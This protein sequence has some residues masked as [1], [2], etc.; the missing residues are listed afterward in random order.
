MTSTVWEPGDVA[1]EH[2]SKPHRFDKDTGKLVTKITASTGPMETAGGLY[3]TIEDLSR[4]AA[5]Q[6]DAWPPR[7]GEPDPILARAT[8][9]EAQ[10]V[11][12]ALGGG[13]GAPVGVGWA[14]HVYENCFGHV[15]R[16]NGGIDGFVAELDLMPQH[17]VAVIVLANRRAAGP[18]PIVDEIWRL[19][20]A[21]GGLEPRVA[22]PHPDVRPAAEAFVGLVNAWNA[23]TFATHA[24]PHM[25]RGDAASQLQHELAWEH[26]Q[27]GDCKLGHLRASKDIDSGEYELECEHGKARLNL[28]VEIRDDASQWRSFALTEFVEPHEDIQGAA[29]SVVQLLKKWDHKKFE[30]TF[31]AS[32]S[33]DRIETFFGRI[34]EDFGRCKLG[35]VRFVRGPHI[36]EYLLDCEKQPA[37]LFLVTESEGEPKISGIRITPIEDQCSPRSQTTGEK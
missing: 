1:P 2:L 10:T 18:G 3:S 14:W 37:K 29:K 16:H 30:R 21:T 19:L 36:G 35:E 25:N 8:S 11:H 17:G 33:P 5:W 32:W 26:E 6:L 31:A 20:H 27:L 13:E 9:R 28:S 34:N 15:V 24:S 23:D 7:S 22:T 12:F 4:F